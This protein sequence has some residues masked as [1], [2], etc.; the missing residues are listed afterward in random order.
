METFKDPSDW[1]TQFCLDLPEALEEL[2]KRGMD[3]STTQ[4]QEYLAVALGF[5][6]DTTRLVHKH[7]PPDEIVR[8]I[9]GYCT[10]RP[11]GVKLG[12]V[13]FEE[14]LLPEGVLRFLTEKEVKFESEIWTI[15]RNDAD[16]F[17]SNPHAHNYATGLV[18]HLGDGRLFRKRKEAGWLPKKR[19]VELRSR[20][21]EALGDIQLPNLAV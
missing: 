10:E 3:I 21:Q 9:V 11:P 7:L 6:E 2:R 13:R 4:A 17:P 16:P 19:L 5:G 18:I 1:I 20:I 14:S 8:I 15:H 12:E